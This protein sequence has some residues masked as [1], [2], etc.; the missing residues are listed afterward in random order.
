MR[1]T[2][3]SGRDSEREHRFELSIVIPA[4]DEANRIGEAVRCI[5]KYLGER[6]PFVELLVVDDGSDDATSEI[7]VDMASALNLGVRVLHHTPGRGKGYAVRR[8]VLA[9]R[10]DAVLVTDA[11][12][13]VSIDHLDGFLALLTGDTDVVMGSRRISGARVEIRQSVLREMLGAAFRELATFLL[14]PGVSDLTCG[15][16]LFSR[17]AAREIFPR[18]RVDGW[19]YDVETY[20]VARRRG[21]VVAELPVTWRDDPDSRVRLLQD[22]P[23]S[24]ADLARIFWNDRLGRYASSVQ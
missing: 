13:S 24:L 8:G 4:R 22:V 16:K 3:D 23:R 9:A 15:F 7:V 11:D 18:L 17:R 2:E 12:L 10:G 20:V 5:A 14:T 19:G 21:L 1:E 6:C